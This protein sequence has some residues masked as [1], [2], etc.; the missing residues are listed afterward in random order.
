MRNLN[1]MLILGV[2]MC[3]SAHMLKY[4]NSNLTQIAI[5]IIEYLTRKRRGENNAEPSTFITR[6]SRMKEKHGIHEWKNQRIAIACSFEYG[7]RE[8]TIFNS[9]Y[10]IR[11]GPV[12]IPVP[13]NCQPILWFSFV[14]MKLNQIKQN[15]RF[16][17]AVYSQFC[18]TKYLPAN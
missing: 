5:K 14:Q 16:V 12:H 7:S 8:W 13:H 9:V 11:F 18:R 15:E 17:C 6:T 4:E 3:A 2:F 1:Q 10:K